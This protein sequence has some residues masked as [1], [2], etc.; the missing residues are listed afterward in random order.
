MKSLS[1]TA[2]YIVGLLEVERKEI[3]LQCMVSLRL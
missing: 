2:I 3:E 1:G